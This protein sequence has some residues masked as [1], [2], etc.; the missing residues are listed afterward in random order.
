MAY[1]TINDQYAQEFITANDLHKLQQRISKAHQELH[2]KTGL[3]NEY[4]GW[5]DYPIKI[6]NEEIEKIIVTAEKIKQHS[7]ILLVIGVGGSYLGARAAIELL[8]HTFINELPAE[9][10]NV[11]RIIFVGHHLS[12]TYMKDL[13]DLLN[14]HEISVN[15]ISKSGSTTETSIAFRIIKK[16]M[17]TR[18]SEDELRKRIFVTTG[19]HNGPL[20]Q[21]ATEEKFETFTIPDDIGGRYSVLTAVG[22]LP[23][24]V[25]GISIDDILDG[26]RLAYTETKSDNIRENNSYFYAA[27]RNVFYQQEKKV[28]IFSTY[29]PRWKY[30]QEWWKQLFGESEG[31]NGKGIFPASATFTTDLHSLGQ[32]I[33]EGE[34]HLFQTILFA[35][36]LSKDVT[37]PFEKNDVDQLNFLANKTIHNINQY[38]FEGAL[39]A[40]TSGGVPNIVINVPKVN[41]FT[42]GYLVYFF[43]KACAMSG[44]LLGVNPFNQPGVEE[45]KRNMMMI[46]HEE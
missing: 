11:P 28:E 7:D 2:K 43:Q 12:G 39:L 34:R 20:K 6:K 31:K 26:A 40:H 17:K 22:L 4:L 19:D 10:R 46:I 36:E 15:V 14:G 30:F 5:L 32:Y 3:G 37:I 27:L 24:A 29:E 1:I 45:Y 35:D 38:A 42:F 21:V 44:Y 23:I 9:K 41:S 13:F 8:S 16:Y 33:Q 25:S 18:Y